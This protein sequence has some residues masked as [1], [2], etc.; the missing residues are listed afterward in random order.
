MLFA[1]ATILTAFIHLRYGAPNPPHIIV[2]MYLAHTVFRKVAIDRHIVY[3]KVQPPLFSQLRVHF[4]RRNCRD[5]RNDVRK[6]RGVTAMLN[7]N[8]KQIS[9]THRASSSSS[10]QTTR[11]RSVC[12]SLCGVAYR[13]DYLVFGCWFFRLLFL[14][15]CALDACDESVWVP[16]INLRPLGNCEN[17]PCRAKCFVFVVCRG[18][19]QT[20]YSLFY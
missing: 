9:T 1:S 5:A 19:C 12:L 15:L 18:I 6:H 4:L 3:T 16:Q 2:R 11:A 8:A 17:A 13:D 7:G 14:L 20:Q 10:S